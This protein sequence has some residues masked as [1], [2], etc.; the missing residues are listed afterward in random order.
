MIYKYSKYV[1]LILTISIILMSSVQSQQFSNAT[2]S[3]D[4]KYNDSNSEKSVPLLLPQTDTG[5]TYPTGLAPT[6]DKAYGYD[7]AHQYYTNYAGW[8]ARNSEANYPNKDKYHI[9]VDIPAPRGTPVY[10]ITDGEIVW[11]STGG[12]GDGNYGLLIKHMFCDEND[13]GKGK[14]FL[15]L[16]GHVRPKQQLS[17]GQV[18]PPVPVSPMESFATIGPWYDTDH[19][20]FGIRSDMNNVVTGF[21]PESQWTDKNQVPPT[22]GFVDPIRWIQTHKPLATSIQKPTVTNGVGATSI[23]TNSARLNGEITNTGGE[24]PI[25]LIYWTDPNDKGAVHVC[26]QGTLGLGKFYVDISGLSPGT[27]YGY[28]CAATNSAGT[29]WTSSTQ[30]TTESE[31]SEFVA[32]RAYNSQYLCAEGGGGGAVVAN[33]NA[34]GA[35]ETFKLIDRGNGNVALRAANGQYVCAEGGGSGAVVANRNAIGAWETFKLIDRGNGN[36]ALQAANGQYVCAEGGGGGA[37]VANRNAI[38]A[39][40]TFKLI[41][42]RNS[43]VALQAANGQYVCAEGGGGGAVVANRNAIGAWETFKLIDRGNGNVALQAANGQYVCAE[44]GGGGAVVANRNAIGA[45]ET[46]KLIPR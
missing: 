35:W 27:T 9:G 21:L 3:N 24:N 31:T 14:E 43:N 6:I 42:R 33:R 11:A 8:L 26:G 20:H 16:Y 38:G 13:N 28:N 23:T 37:V 17:P 1:Y 18:D 19:L 46:F 39:W 45:W 7:G 36:V 22:D 10:P 30:F 5:F 29:S 25:V 32:L 40:E 12:W 4:T 34:I 2:L 15:A 44:G 41:D